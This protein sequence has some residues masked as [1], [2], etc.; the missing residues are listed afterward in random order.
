LDILNR[1]RNHEIGLADASLA[2]LASRYRTRRLLT[3]DRRHFT[4]VHTL[5]GEP[6]QILPG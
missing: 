4:V 2:V 6:F 5:D 1:Y 3:L